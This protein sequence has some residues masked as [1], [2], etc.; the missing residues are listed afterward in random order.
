MCILVYCTLTHPSSKLKCNTLTHAHNCAPVTPGSCIHPLS[1]GLSI[2]SNLLLII[3]MCLCLCIRSPWMHVSLKYRLVHVCF[4]GVNAYQSLCNLAFGLCLRDS[5]V[6]TCEAI[7]YSS[8]L[9]LDTCRVNVSWFTSISFQWVGT[10]WVRM[11]YPWQC[12][13]EYRRMLCVYE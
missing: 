6:R 9:L 13:W 8:L 1:S 2:I 3:F 11:L 12:S 10:A 7:T 4:K 5:S